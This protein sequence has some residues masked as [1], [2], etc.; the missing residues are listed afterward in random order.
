MNKQV[1]GICGKE[2]NQLHRHQI[3]CK[4]KTE[5]LQKYNFNK[6]MLQAELNTLG[7]IQ[8]FIKKY[9]EMTN[10]AYKLFEQFG[11]ST[12]IKLAA[13]HVNIWNKRETTNLE[14]YGAKHNFCHDS[15]SRQRW[16]KRMFDEEGITT[17]FQ[18]DSVKK[19]SKETFLEKYGEVHPMHVGFIKDKCAKNR[20]IGENTR[21]FPK[22][23]FTKIH[24]KVVNYLIQN[25][26]SCKTE[27]HLK[28]KEEGR[29]YRYDIQI[30][31][32][33]KL[34]EVNGDYYHGNPKIYK[35]D[36][37]FNIYPGEEELM[38]DVWK[39]DED[40]TKYAIQCGYKVMTVW[41]YDLNN[42]E[43][44]TLAKVLEYATSKD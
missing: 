13:N 27:F 19:K 35:A 8:E 15:T 6:E 37:I 41:E 25:G 33:N 12:S 42:N 40:K 26:Y 17:V 23:I 29:F 14:R 18:R 20:C 4:R 38:K 7:S 30:L 24:K 43:S 31:N 9:P 44:E 36:D 16:Q 34:I 32:T 2:S 11:I 39:K 28:R 21:F 1:C 3:W 22:Q 10:G 5:F